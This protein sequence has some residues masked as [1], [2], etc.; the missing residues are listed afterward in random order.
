MWVCQLTSD[1]KILVGKMETEAMFSDDEG[2]YQ[3]QYSGGDDKR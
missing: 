1:G 3:L 2:N